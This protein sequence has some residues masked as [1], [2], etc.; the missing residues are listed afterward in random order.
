M[1]I[2]Q[3]LNVLTFVMSPA[4]LTRLHQCLKG[5]W[6][7]VR[8]ELVAETR[9]QIGMALFGDHLEG[10]LESVVDGKIQDHRDQLFGSGKTTLSFDDYQGAA[11]R[12][13]QEVQELDGI[14][15]LPWR[16]QVLLVSKIAI[17]SRL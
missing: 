4:R 10:I 9:T 12:C 8:A 3:S 14:A 17:V 13:L 1:W 7:R 16:R 15:K 6:S 11:S 2:G 5:A